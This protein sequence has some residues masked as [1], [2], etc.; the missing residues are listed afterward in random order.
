MLQIYGYLRF[1]LLSEINNPAYFALHGGLDQGTKHN[2][3]RRSVPSENSSGRVH[4]A[5]MQ[6][7]A[8]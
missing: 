7:T 3:V 5:A 8:L 1:S 2:L 4:P 6:T